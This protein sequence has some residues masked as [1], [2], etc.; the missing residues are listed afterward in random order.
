[1][2]LLHHA[3][4]TMRRLD[5]AVASAALFL[6]T[7]LVA[8]ADLGALTRSRLIRALSAQRAARQDRREDGRR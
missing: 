4:R 3:A 1:M 5:P 8:E 7:L 6:A 2:T